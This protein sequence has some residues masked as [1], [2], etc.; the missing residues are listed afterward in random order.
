MKLVQRSGT[1]IGLFRIALFLLFIFSIPAKGDEG[2]GIVTII[3]VDGFGKQLSPGT[4]VVKDQSGRDVYSATT[5]RANVNL[6][7][8]SYSVS[9]DAIYSGHFQ[10]HLIVDGPRKI[11]YLT[12]AFEVYHD[13]ALPT[14]AVTFKLVPDGTCPAESRFSIMLTGLF[15]DY[16][17]SHPVQQ[18]G[19]IGVALFEPLKMGRYLAAVLEGNV[20]RA[21]QSVDTSGKLTSVTIPLSCGPSEEALPIKR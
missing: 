8:G 6:P 15:I 17:E 10:R 4:L 18:A 3:V 13:L 19:S 1:W 16:A 20:V 11:F 2:S 9:F 21:V 7:Y 12:T 5:E 14:A